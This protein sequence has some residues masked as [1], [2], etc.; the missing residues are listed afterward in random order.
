MYA[1]AV[2]TFVGLSLVTLSSLNEYH[3]SLAPGKGTCVRA[4][5]SLWLLSWA[6]SSLLKEG[7]AGSRAHARACM[8]ARTLT[9]THT[10]THTH[11][12]VHM[13]ARTPTHPCMCTHAQTRAHAR[14]HTRTH[15]GRQTDRQTELER[16]DGCLLGRTQ[17]SVHQPSCP[18]DLRQRRDRTQQRNLAPE[19]P[20]RSQSSSGA[21]PA[22]TQNVSPSSLTNVFR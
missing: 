10:H 12:Q 15:T 20:H 6:S 8:H 1:L 9:H 18:R 7:D 22:G 4:A 16:G 11:T 2:T 13:H 3:C 21:D 19:L 5:A 17:C 14:T